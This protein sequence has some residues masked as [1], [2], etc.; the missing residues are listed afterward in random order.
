[1]IETTN[2]QSDHWQTSKCTDDFDLDIIPVA[3]IMESGLLETTDSPFSFAVGIRPNLMPVLANLERQG[4]WLIVGIAGSGKTTFIH[5]LIACLMY[6]SSPDE[7]QFAISSLKS[8][9]NQ[10]YGKSLHLLQPII[11]TAG[12]AAEILEWASKEMMRRYFLFS[13][14]DI[15]RINE[16]NAV[17]QREGNP[18][19]P[20]IVIIIDELKQV[21]DADKQ[22]AEDAICRIGLM[23]KSA[24][25]HLILSTQHVEPSVIT[26]PIKANIGHRVAF[27]CASELESCII[28]DGSG[29]E[30]L[31]HPGSLL[32][33]YSTSRLVKLRGYY[34]D[35]NELFSATSRIGHHYA[36]DAIEQNVDREISTELH[37]DDA[38]FRA[39]VELVLHS[40]A[41]TV[42]LLQRKLKLKYCMAA[43]LIDEMEEKGIVGPFRGD[44]PR[45]ILISETMWKIWQNEQ[46]SNN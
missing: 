14:T 15:R 4:S 26:A 3:H 28:I 23:G 32:F 27:R 44:K 40:G 22:S 21:M 10:V 36:D 13:K 45:D 8:D 33:R 30:K 19:L 17:A 11:T 12:Q 42:S 34:S 35:P 9:E 29:A 5:S 16:Y 46:H 38:L 7:L 43:L 1:M 39:A 20:R 25:I 41:A 31:E 24:G 2:D 6:K 18:I 37:I